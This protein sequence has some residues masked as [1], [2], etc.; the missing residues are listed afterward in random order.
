M[1]NA[2]LKAAFVEDG[3]IALGTMGSAMPKAEFVTMGDTMPKE[4][5]GVEARDDLGDAGAL[6]FGT[7]VDMATV[8]TLGDRD[9][10]LAILLGIWLAIID[11]PL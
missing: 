1:G 3:L 4:D 8:I 2:M 5:L 11:M 10:C 9:L 6:P 7:G